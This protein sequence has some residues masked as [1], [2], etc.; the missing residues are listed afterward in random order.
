LCIS[1]FYH[2]FLQISLIRVFSLFLPLSL[3]PPL[4]AVYLPLSTYFSP[5]SS[6]LTLYLLSFW[7]S[8]YYFSFLSFNLNVWPKGAFV[9]IILRNSPI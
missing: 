5:L 6:S 1:S 2:S 9:M 7:F 3:H 4:L 8:S